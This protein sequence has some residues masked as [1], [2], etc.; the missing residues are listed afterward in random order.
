MI[1]CVYICLLFFPG[2]YMLF[3]VFVIIICLYVGTKNIK[4]GLIW[5]RGPKDSKLCSG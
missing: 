5:P 2:F 3:F 1:L 4:F